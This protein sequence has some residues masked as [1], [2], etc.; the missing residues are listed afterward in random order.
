VRYSLALL[1][2][3]FR[4]LA[5]GFCLADLAAGAADFLLAPMFLAMISLALVLLFK[6]DYSRW[7]AQPG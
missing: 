6:R 7:S 1:V 2:V 3:G 5:A 4:F